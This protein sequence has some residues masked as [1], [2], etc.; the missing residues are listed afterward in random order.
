[1]IRIFS[2][3]VS[4][5]AVFLVGL[6]T[7]LITLSL[8]LAAR[9]RFWD[10]ATAF[11]TYTDLPRFA[12]QTLAVVLVFQTSFYLNDLYDLQHGYPDEPL[13]LMQ[14]IG[15]ASLLLGILYFLAPPL[16]IG[17]GV[18]FLSV[19]ITGSCVLVNRLVLDRL[20]LVAPA[21]NTLV[22]GGGQLAG[23]VIQEIAKRPDLKFNLVGFI[24]TGAVECSFEAR[25]GVPLL[26]GVSDLREIAENARVARI[27]VAL[28]DRRGVQ[29][30]AA[31]VRLRVQGVLVEDAHSVISALT[32]RVWLN[33]VR[34]SWF[35]FSDG[36]HRSGSTALLKRML[37]ICCATAGFVLSAPIMFIVALAVKLDSP[38]PFLYRQTR[39][40][41]KGKHFNVLKFRSM[42][43]D[44]ESGSGAQ[45][46]SVND[47]RVT[48]IGKFL[49]KYRLDE[50]PQFIN[51][52]RGDMS[53]VGPRPERPF[54]VD[55]LRE[56]IPYYDERHSVRPGL[57]GWA[58]VQYPY[59]S[60]FD[61]AC[62]KLEYDLFYLK[63]MSF[64]FDC[65]IVFQTIRIVLG[66]R[67]GR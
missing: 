51:V 47:P 25:R 36:F 7:A 34:P 55:Q 2:Q 46:S 21:Q 65:V 45:W 10:D 27:I 4:P 67:H 28:E 32:G 3:Y 6:E 37:D 49:R 48:R 53:F 1:M 39:V 63:N 58:Q 9:L 30:T 42:R 18:F 61:D 15:G 12:W 13:R 40:G 33:T 57:T 11:Y 24:H 26:G 31:L 23:M 60:T 56:K 41:W 17:R 5:K 64:I 66:G 8:L 14:S 52:L 43:T 50:L 20:W 35:V 54:F 22:L 19:A 29:P 38:G 44:A 16:L 59:G 62:R